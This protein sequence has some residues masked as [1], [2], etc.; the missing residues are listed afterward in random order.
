MTCVSPLRDEFQTW[1]YQKTALLYFLSQSTVKMEKRHT[2]FGS[3]AVRLCVTET[4]HADFASRCERA[5]L[6]HTHCDAR[7]LRLK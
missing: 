1:P 5:Q 4:P 2:W 7:I 3:K 6:T